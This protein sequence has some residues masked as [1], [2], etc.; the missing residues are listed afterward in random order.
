LRQRCARA[1]RRT[2][3]SS[4]CRPTGSA[5]RGVAR[6]DPAAQFHE[7]SP[8]SVTALTSL[9]GLLAAAERADKGERI[10]FRDPIAAHGVAA[11]DAM[12]P[13][14]LRPDLG[15]F[16]VRVL[17]KVAETPAD[18]R[19]AM[20][21]LESVDRS[22]LPPAVAGD[23]TDA[24]GRLRPGG[25]GAKA[26]PAPWAGYAT[27]SD[28]EKRFHNAMLDIFKL[29]GEATRKQ[30][31]DGSVERGYW[32]SYFLRAVRRHGGVAYAHQLLDMDGMTE[33]SRDFR[34]RVDST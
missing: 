32:A 18:R 2:V 15:A 5:S 29:A 26:A 34:P 9:T 31:P 25:A 28:A 27:A 21:A 7:H 17:E 6:V 19:S 33:V 10:Q 24:I 16:A 3:H 13:W 11:A 23:V 14:L 30:R 20:R 12:R 1:D 8:R 22:E 4:G